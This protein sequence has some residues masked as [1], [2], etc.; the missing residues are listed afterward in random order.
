MPQFCGV[1][2]FL[3]LGCNHFFGTEEEALAS[4]IDDF[5]D[6]EHLLAEGDSFRVCALC[7]LLSSSR[8]EIVDDDEQK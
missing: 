6:C 1:A 3:C 5:I 4:H 7:G 8:L 2:R